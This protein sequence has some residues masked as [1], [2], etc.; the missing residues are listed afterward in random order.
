MW[1][2]K[3]SIWLTGSGLLA[4]SCLRSSL[5]CEWTDSSLGETLFLSILNPSSYISLSSHG[6]MGCF[7]THH[8]AGS[9]EKKLLS[10]AAEIVWLKQIKELRRQRER[11]SEITREKGRR[12]QSNVSYKERGVAGSI[13]ILRSTSDRQRRVSGAKAYR[14]KKK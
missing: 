11:W 6:C 13:V 5:D 4:A 8:W 2:V 10:S 1:F 14:D 7:L 12:L 9:G 3:I